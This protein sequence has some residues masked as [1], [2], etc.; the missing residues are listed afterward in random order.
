M[1]AEGLVPYGTEGV[2]LPPRYSVEVDDSNC[3]VLVEVHVVVIDGQPRCA[4][5]RCRP[6]P[7]GPPVTAENLRQVTLARYLR[8]S[9]VAYSVR[10][11]FD[12][13]GE[14]VF[15]QA[16]GTGDEP[17]LERAARQRP[18]RQITDELL[19]DVARVYSE[20]ETKPT[21]AVMRRFDLSRPTAGRWV[22]LA[23]KR[24]PDEMPPLPK[25]SNR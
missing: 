21:L 22:G 25:A 17:M 16:T 14:W 7:G 18:R 9:A 6:R 11:E 13:Q 24:F 2:H 5:L 19:R 10:V 3:P 4:E 15:V 12:E 8:D 20:A 1:A 23:R